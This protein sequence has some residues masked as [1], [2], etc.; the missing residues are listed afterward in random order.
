MFI[1]EKMII[2]GKRKINSHQPMLLMARS[3]Q[4]LK[5]I[6]YAVM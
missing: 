3:Q 2:I 6:V 4:F 5:V 1:Q